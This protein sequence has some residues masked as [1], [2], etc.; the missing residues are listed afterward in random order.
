VRLDG[1]KIL[2]TAAME[3]R[4]DNSE[5]ELPNIVKKDH[6]NSGYNKNMYYFPINI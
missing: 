5:P 3:S 1:H 2:T 6:T 4:A